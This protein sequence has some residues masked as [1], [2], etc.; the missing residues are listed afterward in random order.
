MAS[1]ERLLEIRS[2][3]HYEQPAKLVSFRTTSLSLTE[4]H[5][6]NSCRDMVSDHDLLDLNENELFDGWNEQHVTRV[7]RLKI[8]CDDK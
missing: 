7:E 3:T 5:S 4:H 1:K 2:K 8:G 6:L